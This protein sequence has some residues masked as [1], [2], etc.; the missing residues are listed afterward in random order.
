M[1]ILGILA[2]V[3]SV[4]PLWKDL[5]PGMSKEQVQTLYPSGRVMLTSECEA[6]VITRYQNGGLSSVALR[7]GDL[8]GAGKNQ[9][10]RAMH[11]QETVKAS[12]VEKYGD[13]IDSQFVKGPGSLFGK[14]QYLFKN[15]DVMIRFTIERGRPFTVVEYQLFP[16]STRATPDAADNL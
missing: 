14:D 7:F 3:A 10:D 1:I 16:T 8:M 4:Q 11:C 13:P 9:W 2:A 6:K 12:I 5:V 15:N